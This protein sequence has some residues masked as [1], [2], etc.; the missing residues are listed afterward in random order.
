MKENF[1][2]FL[3]EAESDFCALGLSVS[4]IEE[5]VRAQNIDI[6]QLCRFI[7]NEMKK[8]NNF[9]WYFLTTVVTCGIYK[10][11]NSKFDIVLNY[12]VLAVNKY[13][14]AMNAIGFF[15]MRGLID[16]VQR[17]DKSILYFEQA[18]KTGSL[19]AQCNLAGLYF[20][21]FNCFGIVDFRVSAEMLYNDAINKGYTKAKYHYAF[22]LL[23]VLVVTEADKERA[24]NLLKE[25]A[26]ENVKASKTLLE[27]CLLAKATNIVRVDR[28]TN[29]NI[30]TSQELLRQVTSISPPSP[31][32]FEFEL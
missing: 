8:S 18:M 12:S 25:S 21:Q 28:E 29:Q 7:E 2:C 13:P 15:Y 9:A 32:Q 3:K 22:S 19:P 11:Y 16:G 6:N 23:D 30:A 20:A 10:S 26:N 5:F 17:L 27:K 14:P 1:E 31:T 24:I 4:A